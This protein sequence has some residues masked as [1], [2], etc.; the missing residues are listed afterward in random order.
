MF[1]LMNFYPYALFLHIAGASGLFVTLGLEW[2]G[3]SSLRRVATAEQA[4]EWLKLLA[5]LRRLYPIVWLTILIPG[6]YMA[7]LAWRGVAWITIALAAIV[8][9]VILGTGLGRRR[10]ASIVQAIAAEG[11]T[12]SS[13]LRQ[14]LNDPVLWASLWIRT[15]IALGIVFLMAVKPGMLGSLLTMGVAILLGVAFSLSGLNRGREPLQTRQTGNS[16]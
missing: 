2:A 11:G 13:S 10:M 7:A 8:V 6:F 5:S 12:L 9:L 15:A 1:S 14:R 3:M 16:L 4:R